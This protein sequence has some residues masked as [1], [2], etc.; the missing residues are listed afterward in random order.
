[1]TTLIHIIEADYDNARHAADLVAMLDSYARDPMGGGKP[2]AEEIKQR[3]IPM[4][5]AHPTSFTLLAYQG[6][7]A[8]G[9]EPVGIANCFVGYSTFA[10]KPLVNIHDLAVVSNARRMGVGRKLLDAVKA[11]MI[12]LGCC[13][14]TLEVRDDNPA[15]QALYQAYGFH[16]DGIPHRFWNL[17]VGD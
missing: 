9:G 10:A 1:M 5:K 15:A 6:D 16:D 11:K 3:L 17:K 14:I 4:L 12:E 7:P 8:H 13:K 2:M